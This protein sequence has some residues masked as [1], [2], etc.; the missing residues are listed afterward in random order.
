[1]LPQS[2]GRRLRH[3]RLNQRIR[4]L[5]G[6]NTIQLLSFATLRSTMIPRLSFIS[7]LAPSSRVVLLL[8]VSFNATLFECCTDILLTTKACLGIGIIVIRL[9]L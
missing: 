9:G 3:L 6:P 2:R 1:M 4:G 5:R 8:L 7:I